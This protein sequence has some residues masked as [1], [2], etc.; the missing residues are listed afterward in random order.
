MGPIARQ[1]RTIDAMLADPARTGVVAVARPEEMP[2]NETLALRARAARRA[3]AAA[4]RASSSTRV[5][6]DRFTARRRPRRCGA[7]DG[8]AGARRARPAARG[9]RA[10]QRA[11]LARLRRGLDAGV[12]VPFVDAAGLVPRPTLGAGGAR[13]TRVARRPRRQRRRR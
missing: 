3:R 10:A 8:A 4:C 5:L 2:V 7:A 13:W 12:R 9:A 11:Q 6:P 1:G